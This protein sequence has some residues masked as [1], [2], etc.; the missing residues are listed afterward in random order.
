MMA[1]HNNATKQSKVEASSSQSAKNLPPRPDRI[2][3][4]RNYEWYDKKN[5][6]VVEYTFNKHL[7]TYLSLFVLFHYIG[8]ACL[9]EM[10]S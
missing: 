5:S 3:D 6:I 8:W 9:I 7:D 4:P 10:S 2:T 1:P